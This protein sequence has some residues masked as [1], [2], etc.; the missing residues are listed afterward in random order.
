MQTFLIYVSV[1]IPAMIA[2]TYV[3]A[4]RHFRHIQAALPNDVFEDLDITVREALRRSRARTLKSLNR[5]DVDVA[6]VVVTF[7]RLS[8]VFSER[9]EHASASCKNFIL[10][11]EVHHVDRN[12]PITRIV[13]Q[14]VLSALLVAISLHAMRNFSFWIG[15]PIGSTLIVLGM[16]F[17]VIPAMR[18]LRDRQE[19]SA[20]FAA[21]RLVGFEEA[22]FALE[23]LKSLL[24]PQTDV[25]HK[26]IQCMDLDARIAILSRRAT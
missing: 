26:A 1:F 8:I 25:K 21:A 19:L 13:V 14:S 22:L 6:G 15:A 3:S 20:D 4:L 16:I 2:I 17:A 23:T 11:H 5:D 24:D 7:P 9:F 10:A 12:D 18:L